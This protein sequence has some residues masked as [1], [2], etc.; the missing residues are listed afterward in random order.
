VFYFKWSIISRINDFIEKLFK[1]KLHSLKG[2]TCGLDLINVKVIIVFLNGN[3]YF[4]LHI[5]VAYLESFPKYYN[6]V[7]FH[8][9]FSELWSLKVTVP[10]ALFMYACA[11][12]RGFLRARVSAIYPHCLTYAHA[13]GI[14]SNPSQLNDSTFLFF[15]YSFFFQFFE[16]YEW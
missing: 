15:S 14:E 11:C 8:W 10:P 1:R 12:E 6:K 4:L 16:H 9:V 13:H 2:D 7:T 3:S 5:L